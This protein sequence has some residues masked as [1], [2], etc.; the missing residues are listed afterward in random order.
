MSHFS[1]IKTNITDFNI[2]VKTIKQLGFNYR[3]FDNT[4]NCIYINQEVEKN[5]IFVYKL[6]EYSTDKENHIFTFTWNINQYHVI[7][8]LNLWSLDIDFNYLLDRLFQQYA[9]N[10]VV[11]TSSISGFQKI[12]ENLNNDGSIKLTL[13]RWNNS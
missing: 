1:K 11:D 8:D 13:Q 12:K 4:E 5:D 3:F 10:M 7:V 6:N 9:Y 2:L